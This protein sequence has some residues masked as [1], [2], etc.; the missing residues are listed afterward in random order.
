MNRKVLVGFQGIEGSN[1]ERAANQLLAAAGISEFELAPC[2]S[3]DA[4]INN[5][6]A[7]AI[8][9]GVM[10]VGNNVAGEVKETKK[11]LSDRSFREVARC[12]LLVDHCLFAE[13]ECL[14]KSIEKIYSHRQALLQCQQ[15]IDRLCPNSRRI[16]MEDTALAAKNLSNG[17]YG[18]DSA[19][20]C[21]KRAGQIFSLKLLVESLQDRPDNK[22]EFIL[23]KHLAI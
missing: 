10:A 3:S 19:V 16:A 8:D 21:S 17:K 2:I 7:D 11:A 12:E 22:T 13:S 4:V 6:L 18:K 14:L 5:L 9:L 1:S 20:I 23:V 15:S